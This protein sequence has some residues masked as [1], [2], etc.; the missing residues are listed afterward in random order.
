MAT[1][2][3]EP[4]GHPIAVAVARIHAELDDLAEVTGWSLTGPELAQ[5]LTT[6]AALRH[7]VAELELRVVTQA[8]RVDLGP[9]AGAADTGSHWAH[10]TRQ[11]TRD[12]KR[13][14]ALAQDL[15]LDRAH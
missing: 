3:G 9:E 7:R 5:T 4:E 13:R 11:T 1:V 15:D 6:V 10:Q 8:D 14:L 2:F 12:A